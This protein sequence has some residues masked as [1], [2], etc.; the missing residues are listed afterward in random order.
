VERRELGVSGLKVS[1]LSLGAMTF[2]SRMPPISNV[3]ATAAEAMLERAIDAGVDL[4]DTAD[5]Y[6]GGESEEILAPLLAR[7][8]DELVVATKLGMAGGHDRPLS[9]ENV[10]A[11]V[12]RS[13][14]RLATDRIDV[15]YLHRPDRSTPMDETFDA[16]DALVSRGLVRAVGVSNWTAGETGYAVGRQRALGRVEPTSVQVYWSLVGRDVE[17]EIV[18]ACR[19]LGVGVV[20]WSPLAGGYLAGRSDGRRTTW[21]FP[22]VDAAVGPPV[23]TVLR[24][25]AADLGVTPARVA[26]AWLLRRPEVTSVIIGASTPAQLEDNL[27]AATLELDDAHVDQLDEAGA[28]PPIYPRWW[29][30]AMG[31]S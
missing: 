30:D 9:R 11:S 21:A 14:R 5:A 17:Q 2:G 28:V 22:P 1:R 26:I 8:R 4:V 10:T 15:L 13:L 18:P 31:V 20:V 12:E 29:D 27:A 25:L 6:S 24:R 16:L 19:R 3:D 7:H 23:L